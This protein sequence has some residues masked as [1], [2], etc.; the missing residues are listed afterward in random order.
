MLSLQSW[1]SLHYRNTFRFSSSCKLSKTNCIVSTSIFVLRGRF[2]IL[3]T[4][5]VRLVQIRSAVLYGLLDLIMDSSD[6]MSASILLPAC[7]LSSLRVQ[8]L[9]ASTLSA[10]LNHLYSLNKWVHK[11]DASCTDFVFLGQMMGNGFTQF[12]FISTRPSA[13]KTEEDRAEEETL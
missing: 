6:F 3:K 1:H 11:S 5:K 13:D 7:C 9:E 8:W 2:Y 4:S 10:P 12:W